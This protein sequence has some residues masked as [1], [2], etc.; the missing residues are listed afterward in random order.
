MSLLH[1]TGFVLPHQQGEGGGRR[2]PAV[3]PLPPTHPL[4]HLSPQLPARV[5]TV[6]VLVAV[7]ELG[8]AALASVW[9]GGG[10]PLGLCSLDSS[11]EEGEK[12]HFFTLFAL[13]R[14]NCW[15]FREF[16][17]KRCCI[18]QWNIKCTFLL[19]TRSDDIYISKKIKQSYLI[20][21]T[22]V[23][24]SVSWL[25]SVRRQTRCRRQN[26]PEMSGTTRWT[27]MWSSWNTGPTGPWCNTHSSVREG[28]IML[29]FVR[30]AGNFL[31]HIDPPKTWCW[32]G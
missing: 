28:P 30:T 23:R 32:L 15:T 9:G 27:P 16:R 7:A 21:W 4:Q 13:E 5:T 2:V 18:V 26:V 29:E 6:S 20:G 8:G 10:W 12:K 31:Y 19:Y 22:W 11:W 14:W 24:S 1:Q 25:R 17:G 3:A